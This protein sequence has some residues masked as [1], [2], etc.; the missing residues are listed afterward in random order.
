MLRFVQSTL[1]ITWELKQCHGSN[2]SFDSPYLIHKHCEDIKKPG[3]FETFYYSNLKTIEPEQF[4]KTYYL[5]VNYNFNSNQLQIFQKL[6]NFKYVFY[7]LELSIHFSNNFGHNYI[8]YFL[9]KLFFPNYVGV[10]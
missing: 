4:L 5:T 6:G 10:L 3:N 9:L 1:L 7:I 8:K 2:V